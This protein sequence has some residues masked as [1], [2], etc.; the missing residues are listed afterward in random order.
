MTSTPNPLGPSRYFPDPDEIEN[1]YGIVALGLPLR[2]EILVA[3]FQQ[4]FF[5]FLIFWI[6]Q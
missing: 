3:I 5:F 2:R 6:L 4:E 1:D